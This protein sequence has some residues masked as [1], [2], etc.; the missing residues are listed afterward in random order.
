M[1]KLLN[2]DFFRLR[3]NIIFWLFI[4]LTIGASGIILLKYYFSEN[5]VVLDKVINEF[6][7]YIGLLIAIFISLFVGQEYSEGNIK[8]KIVVGHKRKS[9]YLSNLIVCVTA[10]I[11]CEIAY[12][13]TT[14]LIGTVLFGNFQ[15]PL[16]D[17]VMSILDTFLI[18]IVYC[19]IF[20]FIT[21][22]CSEITISIT[23]NIL[24]FITIF[25]VVAALGYVANSPEYLTNSY[26]EDGVETIISQEPN[27]NYPGDLKV[28]FAKAIYLLIP[29]GQANDIANLNMEYIYQMPFYSII[30]SFT[31][32]I[33]GVYIFSKKELK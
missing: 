19:S 21:M 25:I 18:I 1:S 4:F 14:S 22:I 11:L 17:L 13:I 3:K 15:M 28:N 32:N 7:V 9:I 33:I 12:I 10:S 27:P 24:L 6:I 23:V 20:N 8:N 30:L 2:A 5:V 16:T 29:Q 31:I 26:W